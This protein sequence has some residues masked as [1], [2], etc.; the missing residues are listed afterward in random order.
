[1]SHPEIR[2][3]LCFKNYLQDL[4]IYVGIFCMTEIKTVSNSIHINKVRCVLALLLIS[5]KCLSIK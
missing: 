3:A 5:S 4:K 2:M 1:M